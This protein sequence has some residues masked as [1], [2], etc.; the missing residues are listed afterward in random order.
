MSA[1]DFDRVRNLNFFLVGGRTSRPGAC[2]F[3]AV[4]S[5]F[6]RAPSSNAPEYFGKFFV[7]LE[8]KPI[9]ETVSIAVRMNRVQQVLTIK[10]EE[11]FWSKPAPECGIIFPQFLPRWQLP[12]FEQ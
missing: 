3:P 2:F 7:I 10:L 8:F 11:L 9:N 12:L 1:G 6:E 5:E 4:D